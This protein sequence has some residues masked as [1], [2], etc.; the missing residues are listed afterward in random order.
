MDKDKDKALLE[1]KL[2]KYTDKHVVLY[3]KLLEL[4]HELQLVSDEYFQTDRKLRQLNEI[5]RS[6]SGS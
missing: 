4:E 6:L 5:N 3:K 1:K 2:V